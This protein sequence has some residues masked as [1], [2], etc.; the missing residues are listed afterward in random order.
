MIEEGSSAFFIELCRLLK[1]LETS[2]SRGAGTFLR[3]ELCCL[4]NVGTRICASLRACI[5][6]TN[7]DAMTMTDGLLTI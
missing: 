5:I 2:V 6:L 4:M 3:C 1:R 7:R